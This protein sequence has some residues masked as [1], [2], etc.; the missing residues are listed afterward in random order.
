MKFNLIEV[1]R[2]IGYIR[3][4]MKCEIGYVQVNINREKGYLQ[5]DIDLLRKS[6]GITISKLEHGIDAT[7]K[8]MKSVE[9]K[10]VSIDR[11]K[12]YL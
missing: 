7:Q 5:T 8:H 3:A 12:G 11:E 9:D 1:N 2:E 10:L 6:T 4:E